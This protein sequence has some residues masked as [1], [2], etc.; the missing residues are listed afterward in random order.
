MTDTNLKKDGSGFFGWA[1]WLL[2]VFCKEWVWE[3]FCK[4]WFW[5]GFC[6]N[7]LYKKFDKWKAWLYL[8]PA[9]ILLLIF[10]VW[11]LI[12]PVKMAF[13]SYYDP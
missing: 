3:T 9:L 1:L 8:S 13:T 10:S 7:T 4:K 6:V 2:N 11:P 5:Q 12:N